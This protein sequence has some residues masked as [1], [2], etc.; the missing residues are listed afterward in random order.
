MA[1]FFVNRPIVAMVIA[2]ITV[3]AGLVSMGKLPLAQFPQIIPPQIIVNTTF[4]GGDANTIEQSI[5]TPLE[6]QLNGVD[7]MVYM[8]ST[9]ANDGTL[10]ETV[11]FDVESDPS[12]RQ[13]VV[14]QLTDGAADV[15]AVTVKVQR[16]VRIKNEVVR[17]DD[18][19]SS[20]RGDD[21]GRRAERDRDT[22]Q[23]GMRVAVKIDERR[24]VRHDRRVHVRQTGIKDSHDDGR[25]SLRLNVPRRLQVDQR[26]VPLA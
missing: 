13:P 25:S 16:R 15:R 12:G 11:T 4:T 22:S 20:R 7:N 8:Q 24:G 17:R 14:R 21:L 23:R 18:A 6:Q 9:N 3:L 19:S 1:K 10:Q 2:I 5:A 26:K